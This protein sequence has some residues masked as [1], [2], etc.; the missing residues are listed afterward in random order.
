MKRS[1]GTLMWLASTVVFTFA[2]IGCGGGG[3]SS[4]TPPPA[5]TGDT[6]LFPNAELLMPVPDLLKQSGVIIL[7]ARHTETVYNAGH[8][9]GAVHAPPLLFSVSQANQIL[10]PVAELEQVLGSLG[11][12]RTSPIV[13]YDDTTDSLG[14]GGRLFWLLEYLGCTNV[15]MLNGGWYQWQVQRMPVELAAPAPTPVVFTAVVN[16]EIYVEKEYVASRLNAAGFALVDVRTDG[17]YQGLQPTSDPRPGH[18]PGAIN[19][20]YTECYNPDRTVLN[21][22]DLKLLLESKG[23]TTANEVVV[24]S[25]VGKRSAFFYFLS[26][27]MG[28][29]NIANYDGSIV[30]W[31]AS[32]PTLYP[33]VTGP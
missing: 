1:L 26:R 30:D 32:D 18:I 31:G 24:Y 7:D 3:G 28:Y 16:N 11:V 20:P 12:T 33:M 29:S 25:T 13:I 8:I 15:S 14:A 10:R 27:L 22:K 21:F 5:S 6:S 17:E 23:V 9:P 2:L 19:F 4:P